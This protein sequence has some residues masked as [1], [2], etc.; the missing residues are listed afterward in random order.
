MSDKFPFPILVTRTYLKHIGGTKDY[1]VIV[2]SKYKQPIAP[3]LLLFKWG[4]IGAR[5]PIITCTKKVS[6]GYAFDEGNT[7]ISEKQ[8]RDYSDATGGGIRSSSLSYGIE[9]VCATRSDLEHEIGAFMDKLTE[10]ESSESS[11][12]PLEH[13][14]NMKFE[15]SPV[16][17][18]RPIGTRT[19]SAETPKKPEPVIDHLA[20]NP[21]WGSF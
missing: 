8:S 21:N 9:R 17:D 7:K 13:L 18:D 1:E 12:S 4:K 19:R 16:V 3:A 6:V 11:Q 5:K 14:F 10:G 20:R 15:L 2:I